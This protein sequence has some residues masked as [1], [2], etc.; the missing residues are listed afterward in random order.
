MKSNKSLQLI[1]SPFIVT[2]GDKIYIFQ[3]EQ[4]K[5]NKCNHEDADTRII[6]SDYQ[7][8]NG[9]VVAKDMDVLIWFYLYVNML[10]T[11]SNTVGSSNMMS[12]NM[13]IYITSVTIWVKIYVNQYLFFMQ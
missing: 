5:V 12:K 3:E 2:A 11:I 9:I 8:T 10:Y 6:L 4:R 7:E 1:N 13:L